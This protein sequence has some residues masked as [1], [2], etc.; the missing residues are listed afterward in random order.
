[1][2]ITGSLG[3]TALSGIQQPGRP[4]NGTVSDPV[5]GSSPILANRRDQH[6]SALSIFK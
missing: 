5:K 4:L 6:A 2:I 3:V 1:M